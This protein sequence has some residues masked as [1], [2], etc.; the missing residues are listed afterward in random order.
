MKSI[1]PVL[2][3]YYTMKDAVCMISKIFNFY[4]GHD[5]DV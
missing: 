1:T 3:H 5:F 4:R 2:L